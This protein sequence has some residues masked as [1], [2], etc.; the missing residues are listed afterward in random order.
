VGLPTAS[1]LHASTRDAAA[2]SNLLATQSQRFKVSKEVILRRLLTLGIIRQARFQQELT[3]LKPA[4]PPVKR[5]P[6][7]GLSPANKCLTERGPWFISLVLEGQAR[8]LIT[9]GDL[10]DYLGLKLTHVPKVQAKLGF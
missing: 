10:A 6:G 9:Y 4:R 1:E 8:S 3:K 2:F 5:S 7:Y